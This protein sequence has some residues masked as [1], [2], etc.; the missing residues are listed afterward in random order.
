[1]SVKLNTKQKFFHC[2]PVF[3]SNYITLH[4]RTRCSLR[5]SLTVRHFRTCILQL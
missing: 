4:K 5:Y 2:L 1:M 3:I